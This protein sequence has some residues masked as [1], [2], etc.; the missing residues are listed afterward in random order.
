MK[1]A[2]IADELGTSLQSVRRWSADENATPGDESIKK[3]IK[4]YND[5]A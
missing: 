5:R 2:D 3:L 4:L 1:H